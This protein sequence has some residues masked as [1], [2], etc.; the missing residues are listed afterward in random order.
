MD[1]RTF[2]KATGAAAV[3]TTATGASAAVG[4]LPA[5]GAEETAGG[6]L[7]AP[8]IA[9]GVRELRLGTMWPETVV[10]FRGSAE[11]LARRIE[12]ATDRRWRITPVALGV[13][14]GEATIAADVDL[15]HGCEH[16]NLSWH[17]ALAYFAGLPAFTGLDPHE[18]HAWLTVAGGQMLWDDLA[19]DLN[20]KA[21]MA[22][23]TGKYPGLW[24]RHPPGGGDD[25]LAGLRLHVLGPTRE[26][27]RALGGT[28][29]DALLRDVPSAL[30]SGAIDGAEWGG[31]MIDLA[32]GMAVAA[33]HVVRVGLS[34]NGMALS[35]GM[36]RSFWDRLSASEQAIFEA[37]AA[38]ETRLTLAEAKAHERI[39]RDH[40]VA[41]HGVILE[42][43]PSELLSRLSVESE[44]VV[45]ATADYDAKARRI[46]DSYMGFLESVNGLPSAPR[47]ETMPAA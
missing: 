37:C 32:A 34:P 39:A 16:H 26:V 30:A 13:P 3:T 2:I 14:G 5:G 38:E 44:R 17:P 19:A 23:H 4:V 28:P 40:M 25:S 47:S 8:A 9:A 21:L 36:R 22:G 41:T 27:L 24:L 1:R 7:T 10:G 35:L 46:H 43:L 15:Y 11:R 12:V 45:E 20:L 33:R 6:T 18:L 29:T 42:Q 31:P